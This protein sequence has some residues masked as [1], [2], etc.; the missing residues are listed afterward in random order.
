[1]A[2]RIE[3]VFLL[4][5]RKGVVGWRD[6]SVHTHKKLQGFRYGYVQNGK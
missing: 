2:N 6:T 3:E 4:D 5:L 1:M